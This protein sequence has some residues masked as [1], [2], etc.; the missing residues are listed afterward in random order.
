MIETQVLLTIG[1]LLVF[2]GG[3][4]TGY[5]YRELR[6]ALKSL[7]NIAKGTPPPKLGPTSGAYKVSATLEPTQRI[8]PKKP[9]VRVVN[10]KTPQRMEWEAQNKQRTEALEHKLPDGGPR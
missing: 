8:T 7:A 9:V 10:P 5:W 3:I 2:A 4:A 6:E 1:L